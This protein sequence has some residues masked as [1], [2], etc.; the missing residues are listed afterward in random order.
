MED[1][2]ETPGVGAPAA[3]AI[4]PERFCFQDDG[5]IP[6]SRLAT[7]VFRARSD[8]RLGDLD[9]ERLATLFGERFTASGWRPSWRGGV[10]DYHHYHSTAH[11]AFGVLSGW[12]RLRLGGEAGSDVEL[13]LGDVV[14]LPAGTGHCH[15][16]SSED[17]LLL[18][19]YPQGQ[20][21]VDLIGADPARHD[22]AV[23]RIAAVSRP[24][25]DPLG[26]EMARW[27]PAPA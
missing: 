21:S 24:A 26:G 15:L 11:E 4:A 6:N 23:A 10:F 27:W 12:G 18:A 25:R 5:R 8:V 9:R 19:A 14:V 13:R 16:E 7:L 3:E 22:A 17:F 1:E 20:P 2:L